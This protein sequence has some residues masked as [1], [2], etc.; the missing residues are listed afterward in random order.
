M[1]DSAREGI[2]QRDKETLAIVPKIPMGLLSPEMLEKIAQTAKKYNIPVLKITSAQRIALVGIKKEDVE[3]VWHE[4]EMEIGF[5]VGACLHYVQ[6]CPGT[7]ACRLAQRNSLAMAQTLDELL[8][9]MEIP[10]KTKVGISGCPLSCGEGFVRDIGLFGK[11]DAG[12]TVIIGGNS[13]KNARIGDVLAEDLSDEDTVALI[14]KLADY[15]TAN[16]KGRERMYRFVPR[17]GIE[18]IRDAIGVVN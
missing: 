17:I 11:K 3:K 14:K 16:A 9:Q 7:E 4:L 2:L 15:Y 10:A 6:A 12:W 13:G 18:T 5:P 8:S 1:S